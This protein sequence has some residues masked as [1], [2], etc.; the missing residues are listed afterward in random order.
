MQRSYLNILSCRNILPEKMVKERRTD[1]LT[2]TGNGRE[3]DK[4]KNKQKQTKKWKTGFLLSS[5]DHPDP[6]L[7]TSTVYHVPC[8]IM[9][10][11]DATWHAHEF[12]P[13]SPGVSVGRHLYPSLYCPSAYSLYVPRVGRLFVPACSLPFRHKLIGEF[14]LLGWR[15]SLCSLEKRFRRRRM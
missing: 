1:C 3:R 2:N 11:T 8:H 9:E 6:F 13:W 10:T 14:A 12:V 4:L 5:L 7:H 15:L